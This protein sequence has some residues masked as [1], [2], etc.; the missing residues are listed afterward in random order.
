M[1][2]MKFVF[3]GLLLSLNLLTPA[4]MA[5]SRIEKKLM[6]FGGPETRTRCIKM[7]KTKGIPTCKVKGFKV[8]C[9]DNWI[10]GCS[11]WATDF[12]QHEIFL[13]AT[14]PD[15]E[16][17]LQRVLQNALERSMAAALVA[18]AATPGEVAARAAAAF[19]AFKVA[20]A[21]ELAVEPVLASI[22]DQFSIRI[23]ERGHW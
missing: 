7:W 9:T 12:Y 17:T 6:Q 5:E 1:T 10:S 21:A 22:K 4:A 19:A 16:E 20:L 3:A 2:S 11:E 14:G 13:V 8:R 15:V 18:A 23:E